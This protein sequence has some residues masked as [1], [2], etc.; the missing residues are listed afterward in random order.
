MDRKVEG[1]VKRCTGCQTHA[2]SPAEYAPLHPWSYM[3]TAR[4]WSR[5]RTRG[6]CWSLSG[7]VLSDSDSKWMEVEVFVVH[8]TFESTSRFCSGS[9]IATHALPEMCVRV[10]K[11]LRP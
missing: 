7:K 10:G 1:L 5:V 3:Q 2:R 6:F 8:H 11:L 4:P 9:L